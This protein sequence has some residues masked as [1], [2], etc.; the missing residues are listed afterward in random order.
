MRIVIDIDDEDYKRIQDIPDVF[1]SL[2][3]RAYSII[4]DGTPLP[5]GAEILTKEAYSDLCTRAADV[6]NFESEEYIEQR[7]ENYNKLLKSRILDCIKE[8]PSVE[9][10]KCGDCISRIN[11]L[12]KLNNLCNNTCEYSK[13]QRKSMCD[14]CNLDLVFDMI[15]NAKAVEPERKMGKWISEQPWCLPKCSICGA[16]CFGLHGFDAI[17]TPYC[18][19]CGAKMEVVEE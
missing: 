5:E 1:N 3:S 19:T 11:I 13:I 7:I 16:S 4:R 12:K 8:S 14:S 10:K 18:P 2:T 15:N 9:P 17:K 6:P